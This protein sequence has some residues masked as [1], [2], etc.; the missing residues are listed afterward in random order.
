MVLEYPSVDRSSQL[1][2]L[3]VY[4][5]HH[6]PPQPQRSSKSDRVSETH[7]RASLQYRP[8]TTTSAAGTAAGVE[9]PH[10]PPSYMCRE[11]LCTDL[12]ASRVSYTLLAKWAFLHRSNQGETSDRGAQRSMGSNLPAANF[13]CRIAGHFRRVS[14]LLRSSRAGSE[15]SNQSGGSFT[16][17]LND[18]AMLP[19]SA[20]YSPSFHREPSPSAAPS[21]VR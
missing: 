17:S 15:L 14:D 5:F 10:H 4:E 19:D 3:Q 21:P 13:A 20:S 1:S 18:S 2:R 7:E 11:E 12:C 9:P 8:S 16:S 6:A